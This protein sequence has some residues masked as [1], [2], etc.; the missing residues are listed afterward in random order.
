M[1]VIISFPI[2]HTRCFIDVKVRR[3]G[4]LVVPN[5][6]EK[7]SRQCHLSSDDAE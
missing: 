4:G 3:L 1:A 6:Q 2:A 7:A 5:C